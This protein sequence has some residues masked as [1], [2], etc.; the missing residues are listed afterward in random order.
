[1]VSDAAAILPLHAPARAAWS[2]ADSAFVLFLL[3]IFVGLT[4]FAARDPA[5]LAAGESGF[6]GAGDLVRQIAYSGALLFI[7]FAAMRAKGFRGLLCLSPFFAA[8]LLWCVLS[9]AWAPVPDVAFRR[10]ALELVIVLS[11]MTSVATLGVERSL[12]LLRVVL[13]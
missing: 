9:A 13:A 7:A 8:L 4:P 5:A 2:L 1:M 3:L 6:G 12:A 11:A 10:A